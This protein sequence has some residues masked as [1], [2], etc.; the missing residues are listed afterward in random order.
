MTYLKALESF[1]TCL[2]VNDKATATLVMELLGLAGSVTGK[3]R[4]REGEGDEIGELHLD[5]LMK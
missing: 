1:V 2:R 3:G 5:V 4:G